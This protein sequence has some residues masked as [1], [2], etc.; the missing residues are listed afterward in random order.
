MDAVG[1]VDAARH[2]VIRNPLGASKAETRSAT[3]FSDPAS[4]IA[5]EMQTNSTC[6]TWIVCDIDFLIRVRGGG[7]WDH[8][9]EIRTTFGDDSDV[10]IGTDVWNI[11]H[12]LWSNFHY[13]YMVAG[14]DWRLDQPYLDC[15]AYQG[16]CGPGILGHDFVDSEP[17]G[18]NNP[19]DYAY[20]AAGAQFR[21]QY[22]SDFGVADLLDFLAPYLSYWESS[23]DDTAPTRV[24]VGR[25][26]G[27]GSSYK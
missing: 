12:D 15:P 5:A 20:T 22:G 24:N 11:E 14:M 26:G 18:Q 6:A 4:Y 21:R 25:R 27:G 3:G 9:D 13:G 23:S 1:A 16:A 2:R 17:F 8:K 7:P 19:L 10:V